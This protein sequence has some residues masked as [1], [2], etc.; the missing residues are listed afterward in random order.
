MQLRI[1]SAFSDFVEATG[2]E[3]SSPADDPSAAREGR[4]SRAPGEA[5]PTGHGEPVE[6]SAAWGALVDGR[7]SLEDRYDYDGCHFLVLQAN[8]PATRARHAL[9]QRERQILAQARA[10]HAN[11]R[12]ACELGVSQ[13]TVSGAL[14]TAARKLGARSRLDLVR[15]LAGTLADPGDVPPP[16]GLRVSALHWH[17]RA[18]LLLSFPGRLERW[19]VGLTKAERAVAEMLVDG[20]SSAEIARLRG[21]SIRTVSNQIA[22]IFRKAS[23]V[24][25]GEL[26]ARVFDP[27]GSGVAPE[28]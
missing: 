28:S 11:K 15:L 20:T 8:S 16:Q 7:W 3:P 26:V 27:R 23:V 24:S 5:P 25:R 18:C 19:P 14:R 13:A 10:G 2:D 12:I 9:S 21:T 6:A 17:G 4:A 22:S 1:S